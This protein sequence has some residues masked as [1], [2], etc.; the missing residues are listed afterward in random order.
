MQKPDPKGNGE[1]DDPIIREGV[2]HGNSDGTKEG[3]GLQKGNH[4]SEIK[5]HTGKRVA[6]KVALTTG[7]ARRQTSR[8]LATSRNVHL[9]EVIDFAPTTSNSFFKDDGFH[10]FEMDSIPVSGYTT[11]QQRDFSLLYFHFSKQLFK[12]KAQ[13]DQ[14]SAQPTMTW[15]GSLSKGPFPFYEEIPLIKMLVMSSKANYYDDYVPIAHTNTNIPLT[16]SP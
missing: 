2:T 6:D 9:K 11:F 10:C 5:G 7:K 16:V 8:V 15:Q 13:A 14:L 3:K 4:D 12:V 1:F